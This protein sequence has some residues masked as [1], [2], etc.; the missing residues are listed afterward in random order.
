MR[1]IETASL[2]RVGE[3]MTHAALLRK[4]SRFIPYHY[5]KDYPETDNTNWCGQV[6]IKQMDGKIGSEFKPMLY[7]H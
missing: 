3:I 5:R 4:E 6:L 7:R 2:I 1:G